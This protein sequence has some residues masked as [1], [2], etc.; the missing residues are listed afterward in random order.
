MARALVKHAPILLLDEPTTALDEKADKILLRTLKRLRGK[1]T[2][3]V[4]THRPSYMKVMDKILVLDGGKLI[5]Q[6]K[7]DII[8]PEITKDLL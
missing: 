1:A 8:I 4:A 7:P 2:L 5:L 3:L 6:G